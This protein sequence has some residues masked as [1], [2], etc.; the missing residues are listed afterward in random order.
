RPDAELP[1]VF[2]ANTV[3]PEAPVVFDPDQ[4]EE[5]RDRWLAEWSA[6]ALR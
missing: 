5:N 6:V 2:T 1:E 4:I 3:V